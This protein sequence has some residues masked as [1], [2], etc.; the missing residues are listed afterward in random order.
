MTEPWVQTVSGVAFDLLAPRV[1]DVRIEDIATSLARLSRYNGHTVECYGLL[2]YSVAQHSVHVS[3]IVEMWGAPTAIVR[4]A[5]LHDAPE[6]YYGDITSPVQMAFREMHKDLFCNAAKSASGLYE[7]GSH[8]HEIAEK[9]I[10][11]MVA[12]LMATDP[13]RALKARVDPVV[14][15]ALGLPAEGHPL[16]KRADLVALACERQALMAPCERSWNLPEF[17]DQR[18]ASFN[19]LAPDDAREEFIARVN[20]IA[21]RAGTEAR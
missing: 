14:R 13:L 19:V 6:A 15:A 10:G 20:E 17:A 21:A 7:P 18:W 5:L 3:R 9:V 12:V 1:E 2:G 8:E 16:V 11:R 4:E